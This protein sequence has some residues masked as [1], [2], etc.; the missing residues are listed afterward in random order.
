MEK[1]S[2]WKTDDAV[3]RVLKIQG[4]QLLVIDCIKRNMPYWVNA[5]LLK[6]FTPCNETELQEITGFFLSDMG[7]LDAQSIQLVRKHFTMIASILPFIA[8]ETMRAKQIASTAVEW[9]VS[10]QT[11]RAY[12][13]LYLV[14]Q[15][16][17]ALAP[18]KRLQRA[19][20]ADEKHM[21]WALNKFFYNQRKNSLHTAYTMML[22]EK[23]CDTI[24]GLLQEYPSFYQFRYF[25]RKTRSMQNYLISRNG[26]K[27]YQRNSRPLT[28]ESIQEFAPN[29][30]VGMLDA[31][32]CDIYLVNDSG[33]LVGRPILTACID[34]YSGMCLGYFLSWEGGVYS[35]RGLFLNILADKVEHCQKH[36]ICIGRSEW[37][38]QGNIPAALVT[39]RGSEYISQTIEQIT[40]LGVT[41]INL[42]SFRAEL[43]APVEKF[44][45]LIQD[46]YKPYLK[47]KGVVEPD[48][49]ERGAHDY[50]KD[51]CLTLEQFEQVIIR[52]VLYY[53]CQRII[54]HYPYTDDMLALQIKPYAS[55]IWNYGLLQDSANMI[56]LDSERLVLAL[57]PRTTGRFTRYG[58]KVNQMRYKRD[59]YT[60]K[61]LSG[62]EVVVAYNPDDVSYVWTIEHGEYIR[63]WLIEKRFNGKDMAEIETLKDNQ[64][65]LVRSVETDNLQAKIDLAQHIEAI[66]YSVRGGNANVK[67]VR[68]TRQR[69]RNKSHVDFMKEGLP[70]ADR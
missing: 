5:D 42:P 46:L 53:N 47:G 32:V 58:L 11:V 52:C 40:E 67:N 24:G 13:C 51:A 69:E 49:Q 31:T 38:C 18:K 43:K 14:Y 44:F 2:L 37:N 65:R 16:M 50:R 22:K 70:Y 26:I 12:L 30:G 39:D 6:G 45:G 17:T 56:T 35:L 29:V 48:Y 66:A 36:G 55:E 23:Y 34:G 27:N 20:T 19:L 9:S 61:Y 57:L 68:D 59:G 63:F 25:Y 28:G 3:L 4:E 33:N 7:T 60:E 64:K 8:E 1:N 41:I 54:K 10:K 15:D 62:G 21:R